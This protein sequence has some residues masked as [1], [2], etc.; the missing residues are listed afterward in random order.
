MLREPVITNTAS[1]LVYHC[2][3]R[4]GWPR[5]DFDVDSCRSELLDLEAEK[6]AKA[7]MAKMEPSKL[8][9]TAWCEDRRQ[10]FK[11]RQL[12]EGQDWDEEKELSQS[13]EDWWKEFQHDMQKK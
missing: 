10:R 7:R 6:Q 13:A 4:N 12:A 3:K 11:K 8:S 2:Y 1:Q 5:A 9:G